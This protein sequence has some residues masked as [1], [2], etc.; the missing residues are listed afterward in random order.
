MVVKIKAFKS[1][2]RK[3]F[4][5]IK[6]YCASQSSKLTYLGQF[7]FVVIT[8]GILINF[9]L[10]A[11]LVTLNFSFKN[12]LASGVLFYFLKEEIPRI[13]VKSK[14]RTGK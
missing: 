10:S 14:V 8:Y 4:K 11:F 5:I 3:L 2:I 13:I 6:S 7:V 9:S 12:V 1:K